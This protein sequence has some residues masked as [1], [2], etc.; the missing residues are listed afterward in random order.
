MVAIRI[1]D[2]S[3]P[4]SIHVVEVVDVG[5]P[6]G[7]HQDFRLV[8]AGLLQVSIDLV[9]DLAGLATDVGVRVVCDDARCVNGVAVY[10][11]L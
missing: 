4:A 10:H 6:D 7:R 9:E 11:D 1:F 3:L 5:Q 8:A 2:L